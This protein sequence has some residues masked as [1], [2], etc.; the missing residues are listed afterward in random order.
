MHLKRAILAALAL[1]GVGCDRESSTPQLSRIRELPI[2]LEIIHAPNPVGAASNART[3]HKYTWTYSTTVSTLD[4][5]LTVVEFG[6]F[7]EQNEKWVFSSFTG[8]PFTTQDFSDWY[9]CPKGQLRQVFMPPIQR[10]GQGV[11]NCDQIECCGTSLERTRMG[12]DFE[13]RQSS[14]REASWSRQ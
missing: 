8:R 10:I 3:A 14:R 2:G 6:C 13:A 7:A 12:I 9:S 5:T 1:I 11:I 4:K